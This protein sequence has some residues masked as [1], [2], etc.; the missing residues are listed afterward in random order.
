VV[1]GATGTVG[2]PAFVHS[3]LATW[4]RLVTEPEPV[5]PT[6]EQV[7]GVPAR[8]FRQWAGDHISDFRPPSVADKLVGRR[9]L[10]VAEARGGG[11]SPGPGEV[12][13]DGADGHR[14]LG[15]RPAGG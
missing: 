7:T 15:A 13:F 4:A 6:V 5:T 8:T 10:L 11:A 3:A 2:D 14:Y 1:T 12:A 9:S